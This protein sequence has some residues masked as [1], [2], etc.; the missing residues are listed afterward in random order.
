M[1]TWVSLKQQ[2]VLSGPGGRLGPTTDRWLR[3]CQQEAS[4]LG[5]SCRPYK[6]LLALRRNN[7]FIP[8]T[9]NL[10][11][12]SFGDRVAPTSARHAVK[13]GAGEDVEEICA[14]SARDSLISPRA[15]GSGGG[16]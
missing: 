15:L 11:L 13:S 16:N 3:P 4:V 5:G 2:P 9:S 6:D 14:V 10:L 1:K 12:R 8:A 7:A